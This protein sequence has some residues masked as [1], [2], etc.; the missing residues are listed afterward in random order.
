M[1]SNM[2]QLIFL[3][4]TSINFLLPMDGP[5]NERPVIDRKI[6]LLALQNQNMLERIA[7][8]ERSLPED[9]KVDMYTHVQDLKLA[10]QRQS[11]TI[12]TLH[13]ALADEVLQGDN[14]PHSDL[15]E[16]N[17][18][19][20]SQLH[21]D[22]VRLLKNEDIK[23]PIEK[24]A[25]DWLHPYKNALPS[26]INPYYI[27]SVCTLI[28]AIWS[29]AAI[30]SADDKSTRKEIVMGACK[31]GFVGALSGYLSYY[32]AKIWNPFRVKLDNGVQGDCQ[33][34]VISSVKNIN[35]MNHSI[36]T[37]CE[38]IQGRK[39]AYVSM[40]TH[41]MMS[42]LLVVSEQRDRDA[43]QRD[44]EHAR[45]LA[46]LEEGQGK[47]LSSVDHVHEKLTS[48]HHNFKATKEDLLQYFHD[49]QQS[50]DRFETVVCA[51]LDIVQKMQV[52]QLLQGQ[53][54][55]YIAEQT[56]DQQ[57]IV[58]KNIPS[59]RSTKDLPRSLLPASSS[60]LSFATQYPKISKQTM[61]TVLKSWNQSV[62]TKQQNQI[63]KLVTIDETGRKSRMRCDNENVRNMAVTLIG[64]AMRGKLA[65]KHIA[66]QKSVAV[67]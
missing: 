13:T 14:L 58:L 18:L 26:K 9:K 54:Q 5:R 24:V 11:D 30:F 3:L 36:A 63:V 47:L 21:S 52:M 45:R 40:A 37:Y 8:E 31:V 57:G 19:D 4:G 43:R 6:Q 25:F 20:I 7:Q 50:R 33:S 41:A 12:K 42:N 32:S 1:K 67:K 22:V 10:L 28:P 46:V 16:V 39:A 44:G 53:R 60:R 48:I 23:N 55:L 35:Q 61:K 49:D 15:L 59:L 2:M 62:K 27:T 65:R 38:H 34:R 51:N 56:A 17:P 66:A 64:S 29:M